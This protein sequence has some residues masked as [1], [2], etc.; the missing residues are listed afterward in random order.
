[1]NEPALFATDAAR[2]QAVTTRDRAADGSF[3]FAVRTTGVYCKPSC[4]SRPPRRENLRFFA[5]GAAA[6]AAGFRACKR[7]RPDDAA[8]DPH[9]AAVAAACAQLAQAESA[10]PLAQLAATAGLSPHHFHR[11][12]KRATGVT[13]AEYQRGLR[14]QRASAA[15]HGGARV[16]DAI[17][18]AGFNAASR[19]YAQAR[20]QL[21]MAPRVWRAGGAGETIHYAVQ[22]CSLGQVLVGATAR[23]ICSILFADTPTQAEAELRQRFPKAEL[24]PAAG[25]LAARIA[26]VVA[27]VDAP[28]GALDLPLDVRGTAFQQRVWKALRA[29]PPGRTATYSEVAQA[30]GAP[31][32]VRAVARACADNPV[33]VAVPCHRVIRGDGSLA[34][35]RWG[36][37]RKHEL[38]ER[39]AGRPAAHDP[40]QGGLSDGGS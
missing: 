33:A 5:D 22:P 1:M 11:V 7:C 16:T 13:P 32:A 29:I 17:Y 31:R 27:Y 9:A 10:V 3:V 26:Q 38:L 20:E 30:I 35:Y 4:A 23:G 14:M 40:R 24:R 15:L 36:L 6:R 34:G 12:F 28:R 2:W 39:E 21:A 19:F 8:G 37:E 25:E 18:E